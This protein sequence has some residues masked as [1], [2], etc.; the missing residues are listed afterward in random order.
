MARQPLL[1]C[2]KSG[3]GRS[4]A[5]AEQIGSAVEG[6]PFNRSYVKNDYE[7][8]FSPPDLLSPAVE[9]LETAVHHLE[10]VAGERSVTVGDVHRNDVRGAQLP[11][12]VR[13][14]FDR[15]GAVHERAAIV[16][17]GVKQAGIR[18]TGANRED[19]VALPM[20]R[21]GFTCGEIGGDHTQRDLHLLEAVTFQEAFEKSLHALAGGESHPTQA[22][23]AD[24]GE[25][26]GGTDAGYLIWRR[27]AGVSRCHDRACAY[28]RDAVNGNLLL[29]EDLQQP[30]VSYAT[31]E[32]TPKRDTDF[33][34]RQGARRNQ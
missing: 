30:G 22:P 11:G 20:E 13:G 10:N 14:D 5:G 12:K 17:H 7:V 2:R 4:F 8:A 6:V 1:N 3:K 23:A 32:P 28:T 26:H 34:L 33:G 15:H 19:H 31:G 21:D 29:L 27:A 25:A 24:I 9:Y 16:I 18:A